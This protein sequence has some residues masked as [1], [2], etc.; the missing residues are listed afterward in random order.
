[1][2]QIYWSLKKIRK[3]GLRLF[4]GVRFSLNLVINQN[5]LNV[6]TNYG[7]HVTLRYRVLDIIFA[8]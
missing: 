7:V 8:A 4:R 2:I 1:M 3:S 5:R 6:C